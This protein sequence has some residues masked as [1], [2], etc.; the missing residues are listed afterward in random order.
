MRLRKGKKQFHGANA[1]CSRVCLSTL[2]CCTK[3]LRESGRAGN[4]QAL[5]Y[6]ESTEAHEIVSWLLAAPTCMGVQEPYQ[7]KCN[8]DPM[9]NSKSDGIPTNKEHPLFIKQGFY[10]DPGLTLIKLI[11]TKNG[12]SPFHLLDSE[13]NVWLRKCHFSTGGNRSLSGRCHYESSGFG[14]EAK[15]LVDPTELRLRRTSQNNSRK[16]RQPLTPVRPICG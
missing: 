9:L 12:A 6:T 8:V 10:S 16:Q 13:V 15:T 11:P 2:Q 14:F 3:L 1:M 4:R 7:L 5:R